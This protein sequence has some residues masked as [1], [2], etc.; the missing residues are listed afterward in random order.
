MLCAA[1][2]GDSRE[3][4]MVTAES[5]RRVEAAHADLLAT[6]ETVPAAQDQNLDDFR[7][8]VQIVLRPDLDYRGFSGTIASGIVRRGDPIRVLPSG[9]TTRIVAI[10]THDG[11]LTQ[12]HAPMSVTLRLSEEIAP[13]TE[14]GNHKILDGR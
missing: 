12:A 7:F 6:I 13:L 11:E 14:V 10:D 9:N 4:A 8:P 2:L 1:A 3:M 5:R